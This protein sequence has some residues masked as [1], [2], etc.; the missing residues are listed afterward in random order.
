MLKTRRSIKMALEEYRSIMEKCTRCSFCKWVPFSHTKSWRF[1]EGCPS[2]AYNKFHA[3]SGGGRLAVALAMLDER[4]PYTDKLLDIVYKCCMDG[5]CDAACKVCLYHMEPLEVMRQLRFKLVE[6]GQLHPKHMLLIEGLRKEDNLMLRSKTERGKWSEGLDVKDL[7]REK[8]EVVFHAGCNLSYDEDQWKV[9]RIAVTLLKK[10]GIDV[11]IMGEQET[12]C[13]GRVYD[14]GYAGEFRKYAEHNIETW[15]NAGV[16][17]VV[18]SCSDGY[19]AFKRLYP[20]IGANFEVLHTVEFIERLIKEKKIKFTRSIPMTITYHDPC[21]LGRRGEPYTYWKGTER[22]ILGQVVVHDPPKPR[23]NAAN[24][25][26]DP[27]RNVLKSIP[28]LKLVEMERIREYAWCCGAG[29]GVKEAYPEF[30]SWTAR[31]RIEE[32]KSTGAE[33]IITACPWC[34]KNFIDYIKSNG[35]T[36]KIYDIVELVQQAINTVNEGV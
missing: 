19:H 14:M 12:C 4:I 22:K 5:A 7:T 16:K 13:G 20:E 24:G 26:Y 17:T 30:S 15:R 1:A 6:D 28:G 23:Y 25:V 34:E 33:A 32:A 11:G 2:A 3:Y 18:T 36:L 21:H 8:A 9:A 29:G 31:E 35:D 27:P 10:S